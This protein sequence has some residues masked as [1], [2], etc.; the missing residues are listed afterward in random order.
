[1]EVGDLIEDPVWWAS[2]KDMGTP[3]KKQMVGDDVCTQQN[4]CPRRGTNVLRFGWAS[5]Q[6]KEKGIILPVA[7]R[8][9]MDC[10]PF[11]IFFYSV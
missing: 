1:M 5:K 11:G 9:L 6:T 7:I 8:F 3:P 4:K 2:H 10:D